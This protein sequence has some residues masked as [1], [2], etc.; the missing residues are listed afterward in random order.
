[1][2]I[3]RHRFVG[4]LLSTA[5]LSGSA[6]ADFGHLGATEVTSSDSQNA[7]AVLE[8][9]LAV[10]AQDLT[11]RFG[12]LDSTQLACDSLCEE[13]KT[14]AEKLDNLGR[15]YNDD[16]NPVMQ[17]LWFLGRYHG[18]Y[19]HADGEDTQQDDWENR[20]FRIGSQARF[21]EKLTLHAQMVS[22]PDIEPFYNGFTELWTQWAFDDAFAI[23]VGQQKHRFTHDRNVSS[24]Y[25]NTLE[26]S[27]FVN[28]FNLDYTPAITASGRTDKFAYYTGVFSNATGPDIWEAFTDY[29][30]G[31]S[32]LASGTWDLKDDLELDEAFFNLCYLYS[33]ANQNATNLNRYQ[34]GYSTA[35]IL[36]EGPNSLISEALLGTRSDNGDAFGIS[37]QPGHFL[38]DKLQL[39]TRYQFAVADEENG[40]LAQRRY[41]RPVGVNTGDVY[42]A[43]YAGFNYYIAGH[44]IK[45]MNG[46][47]Y[48]T[49]N[50][51]SIWTASLA[52][53][54]FWG[55]DSNGPFPMAKILEP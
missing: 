52:I 54:V 29:N 16:N 46:L 42:Q 7:N 9:N 11:E 32:L 1:M 23:T 4:H 24:R 10:P 21:F 49:M 31:H 15:L 53:R 39:A 41:E 18:Q 55:P 14:L 30:S 33:D 25:L 6:L 38:T 22:G 28:M 3:A 50:D 43:G 47:E 13:R 19:Y 8:T 36:T 17:E 51:E 37:I 12:E 5:M 44:R 35:L 34:D 45:L 26:R 48:A 20:R 40:L 2:R 27:M